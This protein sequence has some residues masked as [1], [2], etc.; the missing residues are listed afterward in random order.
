MITN[1]P[2]YVSGILEVDISDH[3]PT[4]ILID[5]K[6]FC[7]NMTSDN[8]NNVIKNRNFSIENIDKF[9][10]FLIDTN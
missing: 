8:N 2:I 1:I 9:K 4:F 10:Q 3:L 6:Y 7:V 5:S